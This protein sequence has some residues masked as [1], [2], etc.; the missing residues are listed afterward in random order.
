MD[1][2]AGN[3]TQYRFVEWGK[4][5]NLYA[6]GEQLSASKSSPKKKERN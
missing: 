3:G 5:G 1:A 2:V 4:R 6:V